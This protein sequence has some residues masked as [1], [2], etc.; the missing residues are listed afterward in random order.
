MIKTHKLMGHNK[1]TRSKEE[2][3]NIIFRR[4]IFAIQNIKKGEKFT[5]KNIKII[6]P[7]Y[8]LSPKNYY[9]LIKKKSKKNFTTG[10]PIK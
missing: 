1:F 10:D 2:M 4:S 5:K 9:S 7:G 8:G 6:R 3:K